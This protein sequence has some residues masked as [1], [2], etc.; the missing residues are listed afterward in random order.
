MKKKTEREEGS[1]TTQ[2]SGNGQQLI[3][4]LLRPSPSTD[5]LQ[6]KRGTGPALLSAC[7]IHEIVGRYPW[8]DAN[9]TNNDHIMAQDHRPAFDSTAGSFCFFS[10]SVLVCIKVYRMLASDKNQPK[11]SVFYLWISQNKSPIDN[12]SLAT[13]CRTTRRPSLSRFRSTLSIDS[14]IRPC[15]MLNLRLMTKDQG[16]PG[17]V[18]NS[19]QRQNTIPNTL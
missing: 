16:C 12:P 5:R 3:N 13:D 2:S 8:I 10:P 4:G 14:G 1:K 19:S 6:W 9:N 7:E 15:L 17:A 11:P 18:H